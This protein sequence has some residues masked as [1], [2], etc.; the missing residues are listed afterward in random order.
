M[1]QKFLKI[2]CKAQLDYVCI[3]T[4]TQYMQRALDL[5]L[6]GLGGVSPNPM[7]GCVIVYNDKI[8]GEGWHEKFGEAHAEVN[9]VNSI[10]NKELLS[11]SVFYINLEP[12]SILGK[13]PAC[14]DLILKYKPKRVV[15]ASKDPNP[16]VNGRGISILENAGIEVIYGILEEESI[17]IN[18]RFFVSMSRNRPYIILKW[19]QTADGFIARKN[20]DSKWISNEQSRKLVH[21]W[22]TEEDA[23]LVGYNTVKYDNPLLTARDWPGRNPVRVIIDP[24]LKLDLSMKVFDGEEVVYLINTENEQLQENICLVKVSTSNF[25]SDMLAYLWEQ[26]IGSIIIEGGAKTINYFLAE[27]YW[28]EARIFTAESKFGEGITAPLIDEEPGN[29]QNITGDR[30]STIYNPKTTMLWQKK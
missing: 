9:A 7:V 18:R 21:R 13:T 30:L 14:T 27:D 11:E 24:K 19:A 16:K 1:V 3:M 5:A 22:R 2:T 28:D 8:I 4:H 15:I 23:V 6:K 12:C 29:E 26:D 10:K 17:N 20:Y 25:L